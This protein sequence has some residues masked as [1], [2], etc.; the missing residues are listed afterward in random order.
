MKVQIMMDR[1]LKNIDKDEDG[2]WIWKGKLR[3]GQPVQITIAGIRKAP[4]RLAFELFSDRPL[5]PSKYWI[6][7]KCGKCNCVNPKCL[8]AVRPNDNLDRCQRQQIEEAIKSLRCEVSGRDFQSI[9]DLALFFKKTLNVSVS[10]T[11]RISEEVN[12]CPKI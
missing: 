7:A 2:C 4:R 10:T 3:G 1:F 6:R 9:N 11:Y 5:P 8:K 12:S